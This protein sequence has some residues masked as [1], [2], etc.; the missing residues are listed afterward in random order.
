MLALPNYDHTR[1][2]TIFCCWRDGREPEDV[3]A[4]TML[5]RPSS[6]KAAFNAR[7][8]GLREVSRVIQIT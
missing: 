8:L 1:K 7:S 2:T 6:K 4:I 3:E 5:S